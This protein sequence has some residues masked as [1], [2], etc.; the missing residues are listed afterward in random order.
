MASLEDNAESLQV[1]LNILA[2]F[3]F[4]K[5]HKLSHGCIYKIIFQ[6]SPVEGQCRLA[7]L[8][9]NQG[10]KFRF[11]TAIVATISRFSKY[12]KLH[13]NCNCGCIGH[14]FPAISNVYC[15]FGKR[16]FTLRRAN[17]SL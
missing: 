15:C 10:F 14:I 9:L 17:L 16:K 13:C 2:F 11:A 4:S 3:K 6:N 12:P 7:T 1:R 5:C 8:G